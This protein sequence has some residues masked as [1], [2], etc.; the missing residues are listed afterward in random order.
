MLLTEILHADCIKVPLEARDKQSAIHELADLL[1]AG[2][3]LRDPAGFKDA[4]WRREQT[5]TTGIGHGIAIPHGKVEG[6][7]RLVMAVGACSPPIDFG[8]IDGQPVE[9]IFILASPL[10]QTGPHIQALATISRMLTDPDLRNRVKKAASAAD[11]YRIIKEHDSRTG[12]PSR[13]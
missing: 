13:A 9:L 1:G 7:D 5:R 11:L 10:D 2:G 6:C 3:Y 12:Q 4:V 8:A